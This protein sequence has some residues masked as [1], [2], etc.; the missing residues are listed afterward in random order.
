MVERWVRDEISEEIRRERSYH[1]DVR[2]AEDPLSVREKG[3]K[4]T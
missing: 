3:T 1:L 4:H 2:T